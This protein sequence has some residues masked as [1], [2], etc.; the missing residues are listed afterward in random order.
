MLAVIDIGATAKQHADHTTGQLLAADALTGCDTVAFMRGIG[1]P[2][3]V[4]LLLPSCKLLKIILICQW[5]KY[6]LRP[7]SL[8]Q[9]AMD[10]QV[11][12][13]CLQPDTRYGLASHQRGK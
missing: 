13:V 12:K 3:A 2:K 6:Y 9:G 7:P 10:V 1:K 4:K 5:T 8:L 11:A